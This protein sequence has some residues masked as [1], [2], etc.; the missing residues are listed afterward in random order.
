MK[1]IRKLSC[2]VLL[3][4]FASIALTA[5][6]KEVEV[7]R[8]VTEKETVVETVVETVLETVI[9]EGTSQVV[10]R[11]VTRV[12]EVEKEVVVTATP[13]PR[14]PMANTLVIAV[15][16]H[17]FTFDP[18]Y[19]WSQIQRIALSAY[20]A[21]VQFKPGTFELMP[22]LA[23][24]WEISDDLL[25]YT[26][27]I[28]EGVKFHD[29]TDLTASD[30]KFTLERAMRIGE[31]MGAS[32]YTVDSIEVPD[33]YTVV[34]KLKQI[35]HPFMEIMAK[36]FIIS[37]DGVKAN[38]TE[39]DP[40]AR[41]YLVE[42]DLGSGPYVITGSILAQET[43]FE[44]FDDYW[45]GWEG[46]HVD[47]VVWLYVKEVATQRLMLEA[48]EIDLAQNVSYDDVADLEANPD[49]QVFIDPCIEGIRASFRVFRPIID[50]VRVREALSMALDREA[51][52]EAGIA[53]YGRPKPGPYGTT[54]PWHND[55]L[56]VVP[57]D[58]E[59][60]KALLAEAGYPDGGF[61]LKL[62]YQCV[63]E[64]EVR[65]VELWGANLAKLGVTLDAECLDYPTIC[66]LAMDKTSDHDMAIDSTWPPFFGPEDGIEQWYHSRN[67][68]KVCYNQSWYINPELE[69]LFAQAATSTDQAE[70]REMYMEAQEIIRN[71]HPAVWTFEKDW[72]NGARN[73]VKGYQY[74]P[75]YY[76]ALMVYDMWLD[77]KP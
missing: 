46:N 37:E 18:I 57:F 29:G 28:R 30:V 43:V 48:G 24:E 31:G 21:M 47:R 44:K 50:D 25:T 22:W 20:D 64:W 15:Q 26:F 58:M 17:P 72:I 19:D 23:T 1:T 7:T 61:S 12:V 38:A 56:E 66:A 33:D 55:D 14:S 69:E 59:G 9:V 63:H 76:Q 54:Y 70:R 27:K 65:F 36:F 52:I 41:L 13:E 11:E 68:G 3:V 60:A 32:L 34:I 45:R 35:T 67:L 8:V 6:E 40:E 4:L 49:T 73:W 77:G 75:R 39:D 5:C 74:L 53:G 62:L 2:L 71:D 42:H 51:L 10:E 16:E